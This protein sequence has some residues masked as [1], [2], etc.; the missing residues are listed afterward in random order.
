[1]L[2]PCCHSHRLC[3]ERSFLSQCFW[4]TFWISWFTQPP[5]GCRHSCQDL[6]LPATICLLCQAADAGCSLLCWPAFSNVLGPSS[7]P[8]GLPP[9]VQSSHC[10]SQE[11]RAGWRWC[12]RSPPAPLVCPVAVYL[13]MAWLVACLSSPLTTDMS[14]AA[15]VGKSSPVCHIF[16]S[17]CCPDPT[18]LFG[19]R[20]GCLVDPSLVPG[21]FSAVVKPRNAVEIRFCVVWHSRSGAG[22]LHPKVWL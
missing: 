15:S 21:Q 13:L 18:C 2:P 4:V 16:R 7:L 10:P 11:S 12:Y 8:S 6:G 17:G 9:Q 5:I 14:I 1:M 3:E 19:F 20:P 22:L